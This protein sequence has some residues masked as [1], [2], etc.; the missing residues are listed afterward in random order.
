MNTENM[1]P[2]TNRDNNEWNK[3]GAANAQSN[4]TKNTAKK[5]SQAPNKDRDYKVLNPD[6][7]LAD[8]PDEH[9]AGKGS[10]DG[11]IGLGT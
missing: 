2:G 1:R 10:L 9:V 3:E 6:G 5:G 11:T 7:S 8:L 4:S